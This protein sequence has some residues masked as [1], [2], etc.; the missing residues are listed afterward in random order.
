[1]K[2]LLVQQEKLQREGEAVLEKTALSKYFAKIGEVFIG[3]SLVTGLM[4]WRDIDIVVTLSAL[5]TAD[6]LG[7]MTRDMLNIPGIYGVNIIDNLIVKNPHH[8]DGLYFG[9]K[10]KTSEQEEWKIDLW[11]VTSF[12]ESN[13]RDV[14]WLL[15]K[16]TPE[17]KSIIL[18]IKSAIH[19]NPKY[20]KTIFST[21]I[22]KA[23]LDEG[24]EDLAGFEAYLKTSSR[25]L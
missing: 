24:V 15:E 23:V 16:V 10:Y 4:T 7:Q 20:K 19:D 2:E 6:A 17:T 21:D 5:P 1:M 22:Y 25:S 8:P 12:I 14:E 3:G 9:L 13:R 18:S 11:L